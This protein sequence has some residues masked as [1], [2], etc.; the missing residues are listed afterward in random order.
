MSWTHT[1]WYQLFPYIIQ[2]IAVKGARVEISKA[3]DVL[4]TQ[5]SMALTDQC[6]FSCACINK[7]GWDL[8]MKDYIPHCV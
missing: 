5:N 3:S 4:K 2:S 6:I 1:G 8:R 7:T